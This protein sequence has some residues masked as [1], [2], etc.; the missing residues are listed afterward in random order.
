MGGLHGV[1]QVLA[2]LL[3]GVGQC[4]LLVLAWLGLQYLPERSFA[5]IRA[6]LTQPTGGRRAD[7]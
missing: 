7:Y 1:L 3:W 4:V 5:A 2:W 6:R